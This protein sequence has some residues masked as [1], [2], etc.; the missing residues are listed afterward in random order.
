L[1]YAYKKQ[2]PAEEVVEI[3]DEEKAFIEDLESIKNW[4]KVERTMLLDNILY[5]VGTSLDENK[6]KEKFLW[7]ND[8]RIKE[9]YPY[10]ESTGM[11]NK[12]INMCIKQSK[13][14]VNINESM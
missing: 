12:I 6:Q 14:D 8:E 9:L 7:L 5:M 11:L 13:K 1:T 4:D 10:L 3:N 2:K